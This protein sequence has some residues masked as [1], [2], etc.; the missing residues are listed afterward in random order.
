MTTD[1]TDK[2]PGDEKQHILWK[3]ILPGVKVIGEGDSAELCR[4]EIEEFSVSHGADG[5]MYPLF[6]H[7]ADG[8]IIRQGGGVNASR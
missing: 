5:R 3:Q 1:Q 6:N 8:R 4:F 7:Y 2:K